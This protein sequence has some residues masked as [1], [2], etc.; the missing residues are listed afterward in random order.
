MTPDHVSFL[1]YPNPAVALFTVNF[2]LEEESHFSV[3][4]MSMEGK[5]LRTMPSQILNAGNHQ[6]EVD[7]A[8]LSQGIYFLES[9]VN[10]EKRF[11]RIVKQ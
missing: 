5:A 6:V 10:G 4:L 2:T 9:V 8:N 3:R 11:N 1:I 7:V